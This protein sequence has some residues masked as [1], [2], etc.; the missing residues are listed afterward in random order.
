MSRRI[1]EFTAE[2]SLQKSSSYKS[3]YDH[4]V[5]SSQIVPQVMQD[6]NRP[7]PK[8]IIKDNCAVICFYSGTRYQC[9][10]VC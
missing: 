3:A 6:P 8:I 7:R 5:I 1:P 4:S 2:A 10:V 9:S